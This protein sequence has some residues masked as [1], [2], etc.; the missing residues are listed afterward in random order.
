MPRLADPTFAPDCTL[1]VDGEPIPARKGESVAV[2]LVAAG[3]PLVSRSAKYH[4]PRGPFCLS[5]TCGNCLVRV[6]GVPNRRACETPC[7]DGMRVETQNA[8]PN[9]R[10]DVFSAIDRLWRGGLDVHHLLTRPAVLNR[11]VVSLSR[12]LAGL[13]RLP[14]DPGDAPSPPAAEAFDALVVGAGPAGLGAAQAL[15]RAGRRV[16]LAERSGR[17]GG[18]LRA[19]LGL[20]GDPPLE[21]CEEAADGVRRA[22]GEVATATAAL[23]LFADG[24]GAA[25]LLLVEGPPR[26]RL[27]RARRV[28]VA[29]GGVAQPP[30]FED[31]DVPGVFAGRA[32]ARSVADEGLVPGRRAAVLG[33]G[34]EAAAVA[35]RLAEGG[36]DVERI[37]AA[38]ER[39]LGRARVR[40]LVL[41]DGRT[42]PCDTVAEGRPPSPAPELLRSVGVAVR[43]DEGA[44]AFAP[45]VDREGRTAVPW[46]FAAGEVAQATDADEA[47]AWGLRAGEAASRG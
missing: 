17:V 11:A 27:V 16:L 40:A 18:R 20:P 41:A 44:L 23:D 3:R 42:V 29:S 30:L 4:R 35:A 43:W 12:R 9:A 47:A 36:M 28:V 26:P 8:W 19:R 24:D 46:L 1:L 25:C 21:W 2:A 13:G 22:G 6:D 7:A 33:E 15:A 10:R 5:G 32:L 37:V 39:A 45:A 31:A 34:P 14:D 38:I